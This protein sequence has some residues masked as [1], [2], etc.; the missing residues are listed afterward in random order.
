MRRGSRR[1]APQVEAL[2]GRAPGG[3]SERRC[4]RLLGG[5]GADV[6]LAESSRGDLIGLVSLAYARSLVRD[7]LAAVLDGVHAR[8]EPAAPLLDG[9]IAFA[10]ERARRRG[11]RHVLAWVEPGDTALVAALRA[12]AYRGRE[13]LVTELNEVA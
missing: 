12:R 5:L 13:I 10:E 8:Q 2:L 9:L 6:Y 11:C 1:D 3:A 7:G 4:R